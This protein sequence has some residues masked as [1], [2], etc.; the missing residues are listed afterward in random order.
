MTSQPEVTSPS[1]GVVN[2]QQ[3]GHVMEPATN[4]Q[5]TSVSP[6]H[7]PAPAP[8]LPPVGVTATYG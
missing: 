2:S 6:Q 7:A 8:Q 1:V 4:Q 3:Y 5:L